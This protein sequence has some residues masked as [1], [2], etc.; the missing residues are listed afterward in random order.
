MHADRAL[1]AQSCYLSALDAIAEQQ[2]QAL[3]GKDG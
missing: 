1:L 3:A 2:K